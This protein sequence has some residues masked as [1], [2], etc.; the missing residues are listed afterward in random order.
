[1]EERKCKENQ[2]MAPPDTFFLAKPQSSGN[3]LCVTVSALPAAAAQAYIGADLG[4]G[5][6]TKLDF[7]TAGLESQTNAPHAGSEQ[8]FTVAPQ[9]D[10]HWLLMNNQL[11]MSIYFPHALC[12]KI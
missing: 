12:Q 5:G 1:M 9:Y 10:F 2:T 4:G 7:D 3:I 8:L 11:L 6:D